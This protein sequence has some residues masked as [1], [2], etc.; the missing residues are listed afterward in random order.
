M[1]LIGHAQTEGVGI[2][3]DDVDAHAILEIKSTDKGV[4]IPN[5]ESPNEVDASPSESMLIYNDRDHR[6]SYYGKYSGSTFRWMDLNPWLTSD[7]R[8]TGAVYATIPYKIGVNMNREPNAELEVVGKIKATEFDGLGTVP[9][10]GI[11]MWN[12]NS[13]TIP[14]GYALCDGGGGRPDLRGKF[15]L[16]GTNAGATGGVNTSGVTSISYRHVE[17]YTISEPTCSAQQYD[18]IYF[19]LVGKRGSN[20]MTWD[21]YA[22][23][24]CS[25]AENFVISVK[26]WTSV[27]SCTVVPIPNPNYYKTKSACRTTGYTQKDIVTS[28]E[29]RPAYYVLAYIMRVD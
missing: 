8:I 28:T 13:S 2:G 17:Q 10:G 16:G 23:G 27:T 18:G 11:I 12:G 21:E 3:T 4:L 5:V 20:D 22:Q 25:Q 7:V 9:K 6:F 24:S 19:H 1:S 15:I 29:N 26:G 14:D